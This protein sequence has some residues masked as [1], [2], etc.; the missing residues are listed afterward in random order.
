MVRKFHTQK[1]LKNFLLKNHLK[2]DIAM[3]E[4]DIISTARS[5]PDSGTS[6][7]AVTAAPERLEFNADVYG[8]SMPLWHYRE[9]PSGM[10]RA[11]TKDL[12]RGRCVLYRVELGPD[13]GDWYSDY[14]RDSNYLILCMMIRE[15][16]DV[17]IK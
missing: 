11:E 8:R 3:T 5:A 1:L 13:T 12:Y 17:W 10:R 6:E 16:K 7:T 4:Q 2:I 15:G 14:V 9:L